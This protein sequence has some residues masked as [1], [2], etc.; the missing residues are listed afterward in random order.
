MSNNDKKKTPSN[1]TEALMEIIYGNKFFQ[2]FRSL[3]IMLISIFLVLFIIWQSLP[4][5]RKNQI[6]D[7]IAATSKPNQPKDDSFPEKNVD[8]RS[9]KLI[10]ENQL[11]ELI[12]DGGK[13]NLKTKFLRQF[14]ENTEVLNIYN[15]ITINE[16]NLDILVSKLI[17][18]KALI[19]VLD[20]S[21]DSEDK[22][23]SITI[24]EK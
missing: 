17:R 22:I 13:I 6:I 24:T 20:Y 1:F 12:Q 11:N 4:D 8:T 5:N 10:L 3:I 15:S 19:K 23:I 14:S 21:L 7:N 16:P 9:F 2:K 18:K